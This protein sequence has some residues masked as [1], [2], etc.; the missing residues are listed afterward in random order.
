MLHIQQATSA[1]GLALCDAVDVRHSCVLHVHL[2]TLLEG[3]ASKSD[4]PKFDNVYH[5]LGAMCRCAAGGQ[6]ARTVQRAL[7]KLVADLKPASH[8]NTQQYQ[9]ITKNVGRLSDHLGAR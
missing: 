1:L 2:I 9:L 3:C 6:D 7:I 8:K 5:T 4:H